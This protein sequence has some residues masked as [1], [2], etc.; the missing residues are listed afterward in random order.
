M[1][2]F[3][4]SGLGAVA[5]AVM[6]ASG[7]HATELVTNGG[8]E[9]GD[10]SGWTI[11]AVS[12]PMAVVTNLVEAGSYAGRI[13]GFAF[14]PDTLAQDI[15]DVSGQSYQVSFWRWQDPFAPNGLDVTWNGVSIFSEV[16]NV[17]NAGYEHFSA[18][19]TGH[20]VD[21]LLFTSYNDPAFTYVDDVSVLGSVPEP[22]TWALM[23]GGFGLAGAALRRRPLPAA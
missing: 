2:V 8:F 14:A 23:I 20:G 5:A 17:A 6:L 1:K 22:A 21:T 12:Y 13:A 19:V 9:T 4:I 16:D 18:T 15:H 3:K 11:D 7:A 10:F